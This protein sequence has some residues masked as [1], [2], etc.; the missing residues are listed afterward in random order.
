MATIGT[1]VETPGAGHFA[2]LMERWRRERGLQDSAFAAHLGLTRSAWSQVKHGVRPVPRHMA[3]AVLARAEEPW[4]TAFERALARD[5]EELADL[6][7]TQT[8]AR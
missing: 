4:R 5:L 1:T 2:T 7:A 6:G 3:A 8:A